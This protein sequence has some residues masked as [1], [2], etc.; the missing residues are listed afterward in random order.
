MP[1]PWFVQVGDI[2]YAAIRHERYD[3]ILQESGRN[4]EFSSATYALSYAKKVFDKLFP[5]PA[6]SQ[7]I[8]VEPDAVKQWRAER[9]RQR[10]EDLI[11]GTLLGV[12]VVKKRR[13]RAAR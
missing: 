11:A 1:K 9:L 7:P 13:F 10:Q 6:P 4:K 3:D 8:D 12:Q 2:Y 5:P